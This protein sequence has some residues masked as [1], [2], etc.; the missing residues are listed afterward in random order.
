MLFVPGF[1]LLAKSADLNL[2]VGGLSDYPFESAKV[3]RDVVDQRIREIVAVPVVLAVRN[4]SSFGLRDL[5][6]EFSYWSE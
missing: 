1:H 3:I 4:V 5:Y 2:T 6:V